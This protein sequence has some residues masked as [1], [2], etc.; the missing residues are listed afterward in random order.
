MPLP[1]TEYDTSIK[2][3]RKVYKDS[4]V[5]FGSNRYFVASHVVGKKEK[6]RQMTIDKIFN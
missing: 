2:F 3:F 1:A 6:Q 4:L 5:A